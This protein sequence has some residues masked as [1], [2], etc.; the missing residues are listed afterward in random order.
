MNLLRGEDSLSGGSLALGRDGCGS[1]QE[2]GLSDDRGGDSL[3]RLD[4]GSWESLN[5]L[6]GEG[7]LDDGGTM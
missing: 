5:D 6:A 3:F 4:G 7:D 1:D 2:G